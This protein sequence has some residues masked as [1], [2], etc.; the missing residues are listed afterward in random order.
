MVTL[1]EVAK[2]DG[3]LNAWITIC[4]RLD[5]IWTTAT[6][7]WGFL[8]ES[9]SEDESGSEFYSSDDGAES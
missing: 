5:T 6:A 9:G 1:L 2:F 7:S 3:V 4:S 8:E